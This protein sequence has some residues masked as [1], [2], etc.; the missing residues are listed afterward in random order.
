LQGIPK[1]DNQKVI[2]HTQPE[3]FVIPE[4][5]SK[6]HI[7][8]AIA[9]IAKDGVASRRESTKYDVSYKG[10]RYPPKFVIT[11]AHV[12]LD[13]TEWSHYN[14][15]GGDEA[16]RFLSYRGFTIV[17][18]SG[19]RV[20]A[21]PA[22]ED[23]EATFSEGRAQYVK[24]RKLERK[25]ALVKAAKERRLKTDKV[26]RCDVCRFS[27]EETYGSV[28]YRYIEAHH[29]IPVSQLGSRKSRVADIALVCSN[30]HRMLHRYQP[31]PQISQ[32]K[33][34]LVRR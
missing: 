8:A 33:R 19:R 1:D 30:C 16:N 25:P 18:K 5:I 17:D 27:F 6:K 2:S 23:E 14:F 29:T 15:A 20:E 13:G 31:W 28:G 3:G 11:L 10:K 22:D 9:R 21:P 24:H 34:I 4:E 32:L 26:L 7:L 12:F